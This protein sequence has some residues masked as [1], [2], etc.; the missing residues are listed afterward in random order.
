[1]HNHGLDDKLLGHSIVFCL[2]PEDK[3]LVS[4]MT[5]NMVA[6]KNILVYLKQKNTLN[7]SNIKQIYKVRAQDNKAIRGPRSKMQQLLKLLEDD[8]Y[9][10]RYIVCDD[11][12]TVR[13]IF[14][15]HPDSVKIFNTFSFVLIYDSTYKAN[16]YRL[17]LLEIVGVTSTKMTYSVSFEF[18]KSEKEDNITWVLGICKTMLKDQENMPQVIITDHDITLMNSVSTMFPNSFA[19][20]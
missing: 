18:S 1:M 19:S 17:P 2:V 7:V 16:K 11:K 10:S 4:D 6:P 20:L 9:V 14:W 3:E 5:L 12:V 13:D 15:S 8:K